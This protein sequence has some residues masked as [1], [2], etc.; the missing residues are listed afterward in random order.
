MKG[1]AA[2]TLYGADASAGVIQILTKRGRTGVRRFSQSFTTEYDNV[3]PNFTPYDNYGICSTA[4]L[5]APTSLNVL[6]AGKPLNTVVSDNPLVRNNVFNNGWSGILQ[7]SAQGGGDNFGYYRLGGSN[8]EQ[9]T[10][11]GNFLNHRTGRVNFNW[12]ASPKWSL[13]ASIG[14]VRANDKLAKGDQDTHSFMLNGQWGQPTAGTGVTRGPDGTLTGGWFNNNV[15]VLSVSSIN[16][17]AN[18]IRS[19]PAATLRYTPFAWFTHRLTLGADF[20]RVERQPDLSAEQSQLV[21]RDSRTP[22]PCRST[23]TTPPSTRSTT[24]ATS[25]GGSAQ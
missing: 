25:I 23:R 4:A 16:N 2:A 13:D 24:S 22:A 15:S 21:Q 7:Y 20:S 18:T 8:N 14:L 9:G 10:T 11:K 6:C 5:V 1:P 12:T 17:E 19:T 3:D